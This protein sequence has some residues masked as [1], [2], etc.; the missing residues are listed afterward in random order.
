MTLSFIGGCEQSAQ[1]S[2]ITTEFQLQV[3]YVSQAEMQEVARSYGD[4]TE[5]L[6]GYAVLQGPPWRCTIYVPNPGV[7][8]RDQELIGHELLH[9]IYGDYH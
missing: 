1:P 3:N 7:S 6:E 5:G 2:V 9:C 4:R 8:R